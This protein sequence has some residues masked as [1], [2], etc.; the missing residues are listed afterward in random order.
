[1]RILAIRG[2][3]FL[4]AVTGSSNGQAIA[5]EVLNAYRMRDEQADVSG[6]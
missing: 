6:P 4:A 1:M 5:E 3:N 2:E